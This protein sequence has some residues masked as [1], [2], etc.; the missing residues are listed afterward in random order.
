MLIDEFNDKEEVIHEN[1]TP[2][3]QLHRP[4]K[5]ELLSDTE[6]LDLTNPLN[7]N[8]A[9]NFFAGV[10]GSGQ[11][12][13]FV[14]TEV[15]RE[16]A[17]FFEK[18]GRYDD[19]VYGT[20]YHDDWWKE[21]RRRCQHGYEVAGVRISGYHYNYLNFGRIMEVR[22]VKGDENKLYGSVSKNRDQFS[23]KAGERKESFPSWWD[24]DYV[25]YTSL[26]IAEYGIT[27]EDY[28]N[29][30]MELNIMED[31]R[32]GGLH[33]V[34]LKP[35][36]VGASW[37]GANL[38]T[39]NFTVLEK[40]MS[41]MVASDKTFLDD[42]GLYT[43]FL[44]Q[45]D[46]LI[47]HAIGLGKESEYV[48][49]R[50]EMH[51]KAS[52]KVNGK[53]VG[54]MNEVIGISLKDN[55]EKMR[56]KR[57]KVIL[58]EELG[59]FPK[60][61]LAWEI[62]RQ[63]VEES[64]TTFGTMVGFGTG[65]TEGSSFDAM[66]LMF[67]DPR[68]YGCICFDNVYDDGYKGTRSGLFTPAYYEVGDR[69]SHGNSLIDLSKEKQ[70]RVREIKKEATD[71]LAVVRYKAEK[72]WTPQEA[73]LE[74]GKNIFISE[75]LTNYKKK[76]E[77]TGEYKLLRTV[78]WLY[79]KSDTNGKKG[80]EFKPEPNRI[81]ID[82]FPHKG[83]YEDETGA[84]CMFYSP[85][86]K[87][88]V[89]PKDLYKICVDTYR[90]DA[91]TGD[92]LG[93]FYVIEQ[94]NNFTPTRGDLI[95]YE[96]SGRPD[97]QEQ[98]NEQLFLAA[99][100]YNA[101]IA[102]ENDEPGDVVGYAKRKGLI[103]YLADEFELAFDE[104]IKTSEGSRRKFGMHMGSGKDN[105]RKKQGD[106]FIKTWLYTIRGYRTMPN[107]DIIAIYNYMTIKSLGLLEEIC[108]YLMDGNR[109]RISALRVG[110]YHKQELLYNEVVPRE[111]RITKDNF[112][113]KDH[114]Q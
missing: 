78:G 44:M 70:W 52:V 66:K 84:G 30:P 12:L 101:E 4:K 90:H 80:A 63:S 55:H 19:G 32:G 10:T 20:I 81:P 94:A 98:F 45:N 91:S 14:N 50:A 6:V 29:L 16:E 49:Q 5:I 39:R 92:S 93:S 42:D 109:D 64:S 35:R 74:T 54:Y 100:L 65:G 73:I 88:G 37:K 56:G 69:D 97:E 13:G 25:Y 62:N 67:Y 77:L 22:E 36:G 105:N 82:K 83:Q 40:T 104:T 72:P 21:Q 31:S 3:I 76:L 28:N 34:W 108:Q 86:R 27:N 99:L 11:T 112:F 23:R 9:S 57:G 107:G 2:P 47:E 15:F 79:S 33:L 60:A 95:A 68:T 96:Y 1:Y 41:Y 43:K 46:W 24:L 114:F 75:G 71:P 17:A 61:N 26:D 8:I 111:A 103:E 53:E 18:F 58:Y 89:V 113:D 7:K 48:N 38:A 102:F 87:S 59:K 51:M 106:L 110:I 85:Y